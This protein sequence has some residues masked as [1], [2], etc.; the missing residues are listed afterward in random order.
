MI[1]PSY[2]RRDFYRSLNNK[3]CFLFHYFLKQI[4]GE[5]FLIRVS[6]LLNES[7]R[8]VTRKSYG[9]LPIIL[10]NSAVAF[11]ASHCTRD[12]ASW[13][14]DIESTQPAHV[15]LEALLKKP[16]SKSILDSCLPK[17]ASLR[18][19]KQSHL[20]L[21][22]PDVLRLD[23]NRNSMVPCSR[24]TDQ[25]TFQCEVGL[26][27]ERLVRTAARE[28][29]LLFQFKNHSSLRIDSVVNVAL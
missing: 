26:L 11:A 5:A 6:N 13:I 20:P 22:D 8:K 1:L 21:T 29:S 12:S 16:K 7:D 4:Y 17:I 27:G 10:Q 28:G 9:K 15:F 24:Y 25:K 2:T 14:A 19:R 23:K 18:R 3:T